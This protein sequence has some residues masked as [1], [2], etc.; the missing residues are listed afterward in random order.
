M[1]SMV[2]LIFLKNKRESIPIGETL[3]TLKRL[4]PAVVRA[5]WAIELVLLSAWTEVI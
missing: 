3:Y 5:S 1:Q 4:I 2:S